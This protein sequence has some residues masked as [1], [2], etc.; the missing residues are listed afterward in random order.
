MSQNITSARAK[1]KLDVGIDDLIVLGILIENGGI[2]MQR[3]ENFILDDFSW[4][5]EGFANHHDSTEWTCSGE[6]A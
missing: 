2:F 1:V 6:Q 3:Y 4:I 5:E